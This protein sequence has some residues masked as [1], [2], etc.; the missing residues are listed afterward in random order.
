MEYFSASALRL[1]RALTKKEPCRGSSWGDRL[2]WVLTVVM[3]T[4]VYVFVSSPSS[5]FRIAC[6]GVISLYVNHFQRT[7][8]AIEKCQ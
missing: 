7:F 5:F 6:K 3:V 8:H 4:G 2:F 1:E